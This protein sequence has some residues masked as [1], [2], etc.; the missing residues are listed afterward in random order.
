MLVGCDPQF[1]EVRETNVSADDEDA[2]SS[3]LN[4]AFFFGRVDAA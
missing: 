1:A 4:Q 2:V 3:F